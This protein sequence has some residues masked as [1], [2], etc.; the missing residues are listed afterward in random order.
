MTGDAKQI[1]VRVGD[2]EGK[3]RKA[4]ADGA[5]RQPARNA[6]VPTRNQLV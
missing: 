4:A 2:D 3:V 1:A 5:S 6:V